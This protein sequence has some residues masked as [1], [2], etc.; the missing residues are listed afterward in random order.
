MMDRF[1]G[2]I[3]SASTSPAWSATTFSRPMRLPSTSRRCRSFC[4]RR[5]E[6]RLER[7]LVAGDHGAREILAEYEACENHCRDVSDDERKRDIGD[8]FVPL[9]ERFAEFLG[10]HAG[11]RSRL[12]IAAINHE[13]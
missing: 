3:L 5:L 2:R 12:L 11:K 8:Q 6:T 9:L 10:E 4:A 13:S 7:A 1:R